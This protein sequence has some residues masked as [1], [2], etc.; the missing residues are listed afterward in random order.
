M[1]RRVPLWL[2]RV[3]VAMWGTAPFVALAQE[4]PEA[5]VILDEGPSPPPVVAPADAGAAPVVPTEQSV[6]DHWIG[7]HLDAVSEVT[8]AQLGIPSGLAVIEVIDKGPAQK[9]GLQKHDILMSA[10]GAAVNSQEDIF[11]VLSQSKGEPITFIIV[12][13]GNRF[14]MRLTPEKRP[15]SA[16]PA[17]AARI[18]IAPPGTRS[19]EVPSLTPALPNATPATPAIPVPVI[20]KPAQPVLPPTDLS[21]A[22][23]WIR[24]LERAITEERKVAADHLQEAQKAYEE[25]IRSIDFNEIES[26][27]NSAIDEVT[28]SLK[29]RVREGI[30]ALQSDDAKAIQRE[31]LD[32][33]SNLERALR[34]Q[35]EL[36]RREAEKRE[37]LELRERPASIESLRQEIKSLRD[38]IERIRREPI[39]RPEIRE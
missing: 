13:K 35:R 11:R 32:G 9:A 18:V 33:M 23:E 22:H 28:R 34:D 29:D 21:R 17:P 6:P 31:V 20:P 8:K 26:V 19:I 24:E 7:L 3:A 37:R 14:G 39:R 10:N 25:T 27:I 16:K 4:V 2:A 30:K 36:D 1:N 38:E 15:E 5:I 12:R